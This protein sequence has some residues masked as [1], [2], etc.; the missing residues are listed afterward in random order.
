MTTANT[1]IITPKQYNHLMGFYTH[2]WLYY[3]DN[4]QP[5]FAFWAE[6]LD[7]VEV[8]W[9]VQNTV[10]VLAEERSTIGKYLTSLLKERNIVVSYNDC[11]ETH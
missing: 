8:P 1:T 10:S 11:I 2:C 3:H 4:I 6:E 7:R 9:S 5:Q